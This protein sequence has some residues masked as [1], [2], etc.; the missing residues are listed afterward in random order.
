MRQGIKKT[1]IFIDIR[2]F[3]RES[4]RGE[5]AKFIAEFIIDFYKSIK[6]TFLTDF[7]KFLGDG[8]MVISEEVDLL[9]ILEKCSKIKSGFPSLLNEFHDKTGVCRAFRRR[10]RCGNITDGTARLTRPPV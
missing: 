3:T 5:V 9:E 1:I 2:D 8:A 4:D 7:F 10:K 6:N